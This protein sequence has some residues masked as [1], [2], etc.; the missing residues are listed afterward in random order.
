MIQFKPRVRPCLRG[1]FDHRK[2]GSITIV[3]ELVWSL[4]VVELVPSPELG[5]HV[6]FFFSVLLT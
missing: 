5:P 1:D 4:R 3:G 2:H 6:A